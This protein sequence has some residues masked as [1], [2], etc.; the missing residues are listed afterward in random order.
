MGMGYI[1]FYPSTALANIHSKGPLLSKL[2]QLLV[3]LL[4]FEQRF[5][6][7]GALTI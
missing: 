3:G 2:N 1:S 7:L 6:G 4:C 5:L